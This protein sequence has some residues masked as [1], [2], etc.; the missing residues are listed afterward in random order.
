MQQ[1]IIK[2][3][4]ASDMM[5]NAGLGGGGLYVHCSCGIDHSIDASED[6][7]NTGNYESIYYIELD[8]MLFVESCQGCQNRLLKYENFIWNNRNTIRRYIKTRI[9]QELEWA[10]QEKL[11]N[12]MSGI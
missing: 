10:Q 9:D 5:W 3:S 11:L 7:Y 6:D 4:E 8:G 1:Y 12:T 2:D